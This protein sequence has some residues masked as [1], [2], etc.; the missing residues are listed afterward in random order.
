[1][2]GEEPPLSGFD[3]V[4]KYVNE[5]PDIQ[6]RP[7]S[8]PAPVFTESNREISTELPRKGEDLAFR[9]PETVAQQDDIGIDSR[10]QLSPHAASWINPSPHSY[11]KE[12]SEIK[13]VSFHQASE[14]RY[15]VPPGFLESFVSTPAYSRSADPLGLVSSLQPLGSLSNTLSSQVQVTTSSPAEIYSTATSYGPAVS[16]NSS[17]TS[18]YS[19][20]CALGP[21][22]AL[23]FWTDAS[24]R[25]AVSGG[26]ISLF[27]QASAL[28]ASTVPVNP[29][30]TQKTLGLT[31]PTSAILS[32]K[33]C[34]HGSAVPSSA[35]LVLAHN[36]GISSEMESLCNN[37]QYSVGSCPT[38]L[39][40][41]SVLCISSSSKQVPSSMDEFAK[42]LVCCQESRF[43]NEN[44]R[45]SGDPLQYHQFIRQIEDRILKIYRQSNPGHVFQLLLNST[46]GR[47]R[48]LS[49]CIMLQPDKALEEALQLFYKTFGSPSV[50]I[51]AH[52][53]TVCEGPTI[54][55][56]GKRVQ[57]FFSDLINGKMVVESANATHLLNAMLLLKGYFLG[58]LETCKK[59][60]L[61]WH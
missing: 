14:S 24:H 40:P 58:F 15:P 16:T 10:Q 34:L 38:S 59:S 45:Y 22:T 37:N 55:T 2:E 23:S 39:T 41:V 4:N 54:K 3:K 28:P 52:L 13:R 18:I 30:Q 48:K 32:G 20:P 7:T 8:K 42:V 50:A 1:M 19:G 5:L 33:S 12:Q 26:G 36:S 44:E 57:E 53:R 46:A 11:P 51:K 60:L 47:A 9:S 43:L 49:G 17:L 6:S 31:N 61:N 21:Q 27:S 25:P 56:N 35:G 29:F